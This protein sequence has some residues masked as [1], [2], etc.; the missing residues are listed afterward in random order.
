MTSYLKTATTWMRRDSYKDISRRQRILYLYIC[1]NKAASEAPYKQAI[2][3]GLQL[4]Q[5]S[6]L[7]VP[8]F[9]Q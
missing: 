3:T 8:F 9:H 4:L 5:L 7:I 6:V 1:L 2:E